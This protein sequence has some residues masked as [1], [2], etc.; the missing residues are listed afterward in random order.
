MSRVAVVIPTLGR[1][2]ALRHCLD[3]LAA[4]STQD[5]V[6]VLVA[7]AAADPDVIRSYA[8]RPDVPGLRLVTAPR[9][10]ASSARNTGWR[11]TD[12]DVI[13][14]LDDDVLPDPG[15]VEAHLRRHDERPEPHVG[16]LGP[17]RWAEGLRVTPFMRFIED[18][19]Q[20]D[21]EALRAT[22]E[23][24]WW[25]LYTCNVSL[26]RQALRDVGGLDEQGF[27]FGYE[28]LDLG[29]RLHDRLGLTLL[30]ERTASAEHDHVMTLEQWLGR[31]QRIAWSERRFVTRFPDVAPHFHDRMR[32]AAD[33]PPMRGRTA[34][35]APYVPERTPVIGG[36]FRRVLHRWY[37]QQLA[38][39]FLQ[40]WDEAE[41]E[42]DPGPPP[43]AA[44]EPSP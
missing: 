39:P 36:H 33:E 21:F 30:Y 43:A 9:P 22:S 37:L 40:A 3:R 27:P 41:A 34:R 11:A 1:R 17:V 19:F 5:F 10:G 28:D 13:L 44:A 31:V 23:T 32:A 18:G 4:Q 7:D 24:G 29:R 20:F 42:A 26:K 35:I 2:P 8:D 25:H 12:A 16:V 15:L 14:F 38:G 6:T